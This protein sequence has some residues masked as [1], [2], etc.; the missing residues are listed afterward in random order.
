MR[1]P[2][3]RSFALIS[4]KWW[5]IPAVLVTAGM[6][7]VSVGHSPA[8][9]AD[10][11][12]DSVGAWLVSAPEGFL[13]RV[14]PLIARPR[15]ATTDRIGLAAPASAIT[16]RRGA[17]VVVEN[18]G[19]AATVVDVRTL[20]ATRVPIT[21]DQ[22]VEAV[23]HRYYLIDPSAGRITRYPSGETVAEVGRSGLG[24]RTFS[25][26]ALWV[27][28]PSAGAVL[29]VNA[30]GTTETEPRVFRAGGRVTLVDSPTGVG[31]VDG[32]TLTVVGGGRHRLPGVP[33]RVAI[34]PDGSVAA[35]L[36]GS[37]LS[38][39]RLSDGRVTRTVDLRVPDRWGAMAV[40]RGVVYLSD[41][42]TG[43][44]WTVGS[45]VPAPVAVAAGPAHL[46]LFT[47]GDLVWVNDPGGP[48][49]VAV[50]SDG[51]MLPMVKY[52]SPPPA[53]TSA[54][55]PHPVTSPPPARH[56][57][58]SR[59]P[60]SRPPTS[61]TPTSRPP[62]SPPPASH[63]TRPPAGG[64]TKPTPTPT[65]TKTRTPPPA[66]VERASFADFHDGQEVGY[67]EPARGSASIP[68]DD[69]LLIAVRRTDPPS[70]DYYFTYAADPKGDV[71]GFD[72]TAYFGHEVD[73]SYRIY[74]LIMNVDDAREFYDGVA[75]HHG[76]FAVATH[77]P[78]SA[79]RADSASVRQT[80]LDCG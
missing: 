52:A 25:A 44:L 72:S 38:V 18:P 66:P 28:L 56:P 26:G 4:T 11:S 1:H 14:N 20:A 34:D 51:R 70:P 77:I 8:G 42:S 60:S 15:V 31:V 21:G 22:Q 75:Q 12:A 39:T 45:A 57:P 55:T 37:V 69:T 76:D 59:P 30:D 41:D 33:S 3:P 32:S 53:P 74:L 35:S 2:N 54:P 80:T 47:H 16:R 10:L 48:G 9:R 13:D 6:A 63:P 61:P 73:Q 50:A 49:A 79:K 19:Q 40:R 23:G 5:F 58:S 65:R 24:D 78:S 36:D 62:T 46:E 68:A 17:T 43:A 29:R 71:S 67:C 27:S 64:R 7:A